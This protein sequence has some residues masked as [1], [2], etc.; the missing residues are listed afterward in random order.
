MPFRS[1]QRTTIQTV[2]FCKTSNGNVFLS[3]TVCHCVLSIG[4]K[5]LQVFFAIVQW[6]TLHTLVPQCK[7]LESTATSALIRTFSLP[8]AFSV[9]SLSAR[10][11]ASPSA[12]SPSTL[13][14]SST[15]RRL[16]PPLV[17]VVVVVVEGGRGI[18][19]GVMPRETR[20]R[21]RWAVGERD[22]TTWRH[23]QIE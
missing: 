7:M 21:G 10:C 16:P 22:V 15:L 5:F 9:L 2:P 6:K 17:V 3:C 14:S 8:R 23:A 12:I 20:R 4:L 19:N 11:S 18:P 13:P 1:T